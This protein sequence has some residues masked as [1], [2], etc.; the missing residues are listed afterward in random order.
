LRG[1]SCESKVYVQVKTDNYPAET[2]WVLKSDG[3]IID[4]VDAGTYGQA[5]TRY[6]SD[7]KCVPSDTRIEFKISDSYGDGLCCSHGDGYY[8][9]FQND[10]L[11]M[12]G[13][14][15][16][17]E[18]SKSF[19]ESGLEVKFTNKINH[20][21]S[22]W[23]TDADDD[24]SAWRPSSE[25]G[26]YSLGDTGMTSWDKPKNGLLVKAN[27][28]IL[29]RPT[30]YNLI[31]KDTDSDGDMDGSFWEPVPGSGYVC[32]GHVVQ[33]HYYKPSTDLI[34]CVKEEFVK[35]GDR[36]WVWDDSNSGARW[37]ASVYQTVPKDNVLGLSPNTF[38]TR[39]SHSPPDISKFKVL[40]WKRIN[41][42]A[43]PINLELAQ[44]Y[45]PKIYLHSQEKYFPSSVEFF[46][47][48]T[49]IQD[50]GNQKYM[51]TN[52]PLGCATC[53]DP[54][55]LDGQKPNDHLTPPIYSIS[56]PK[57]PTAEGLEVMDL[58][59]YAFFPYNG[60]KDVC[61]GLDNVPFVGCAGEHSNF[62]N[63]V[64][65]WEHVTI[66]FIDGY[67]YQMYLG[68]H[69]SG[70]KYYFGD[71]N[72]EIEGGHPVVYAAKGS[73][74][75]YAF[76]G[77]Y[78][79]ASAATTDLKDHMNKGTVWNTYSNVKFTPYKSIGDYDGE[80]S[81]MNFDGRWGNPEDGCYDVPG[82]DT[83]CLLESGPTGPMMKSATNPE[84][85]ALD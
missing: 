76:E 83:Y 69:D 50:I 59:Y 81:F 66:R 68:H 1:L 7:E 17:F 53:T 72:V 2:S 3:Q 38:I 78:K 82:H 11:I 74:G 27:S 6:F 48:Q 28:D 73:H 36:K 23:G 62:G 45:A 44:R 46:T 55:F 85:F 5:N 15:F 31:W 57:A 22:D 34:R 64:G 9:I 14:A 63:H 18:E 67:P 79:Y 43:D 32:L 16:E 58:V 56:V 4:K 20:I 51:V 30:D 80:W 39:R 21:Y 65:D 61:I 60:G 10:K 77:S 13:D 40:D 8:K 19:K 24:F 35:E 70:M 25:D 29:T 52:Q 54:V 75:L 71:K 33:P 47:D 42:N 84:H 12:S 41:L 26:W 37:D 49:N